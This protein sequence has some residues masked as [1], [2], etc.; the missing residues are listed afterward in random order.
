MNRNS[1]LL[2]VLAITI[3]FV[4]ADTSNGYYFLR[5]KNH[6]AAV[7][8]WLESEQTSGT[9]D[10]TP[11]SPINPLASWGNMAFHSA[12][13][14]TVRYNMK[15]CGWTRTLVLTFGKGGVTC[16]VENKG[17]SD[18]SCSTN[19]TAPGYYEAIVSASLC[20]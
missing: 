13:S 18:F 16:R 17:H 2:L 11:T 9:W 10:R 1:L 3:C 20:N 12:D 7:W 8:F 14:A 19:E 6:S 5:V 15:P 4:S